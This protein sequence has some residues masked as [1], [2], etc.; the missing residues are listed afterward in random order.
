MPNKEECQC[1]FCVELREKKEANRL[2]NEGDDPK[3]CPK[4]VIPTE[5][6]FCNDDE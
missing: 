3:D 1:K 5:E 4:G 6:E 2:I